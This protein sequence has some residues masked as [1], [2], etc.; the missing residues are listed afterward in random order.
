MM[1]EQS[2]YMKTMGLLLRDLDQATA[3]LEAINTQSQT[4]SKQELNDLI[5]VLQHFNQTFDPAYW[6]DKKLVPE[7][8]TQKIEKA[9]V[10]SQLFQT[11]H[12]T[13]DRSGQRNVDQAITSLV[14]ALNAALNRFDKNLRNL[15]DIKFGQRVEKTGESKQS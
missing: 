2:P 4:F 8:M 1:V 9:L 10:A 13:K 11:S 5:H 14:S 15:K 6:E 7:G 3:K 12:P